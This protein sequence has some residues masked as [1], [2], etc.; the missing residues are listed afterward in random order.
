M[1]YDCYC[2]MTLPHN[3]VGWSAV[4]GRGI[5]GSYSPIFCGILVALYR[6]DLPI[7]TLFIVACVLDVLQKE[8]FLSFSFS[9]RLFAR[10]TIKFVNVLV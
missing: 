1:Y 10:T 6:S 2:S 9:Y 8:S 7:T 3:A 4:C 5:S